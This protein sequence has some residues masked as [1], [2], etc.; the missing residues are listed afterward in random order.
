MGNLD[1]CGMEV[2]S[3]R[4]G[5]GLKGLNMFRGEMYIVFNFYELQYA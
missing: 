5:F 1:E 3:C 2:A 4:H